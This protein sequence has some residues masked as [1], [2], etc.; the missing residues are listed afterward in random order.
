MFAFAGG[1]GQYAIGLD[2]G[3]VEERLRLPPPDVEA[4]VID[5]LHEDLD[6]DLLEPPAKIAGRGGIGNTLGAED[7]EINLVVAAQLDV[8]QAGSAAKD[9][10]RN[11]EHVVGLVIGQ[12]DLEQT[13]VAVDRLDEAGAPGKQ[14]HGPDPALGQTASP[15]G[16]LVVDVAGGEHRGGLIAPFP[17]AKP[18]FNS[19]LASGKLLTCNGVHSKCLLAYKC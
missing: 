17:R 8:L 9:V 2:D 16:Q 12:V 1:R 5:D 4:H 15:I 18:V 19:A 6:V 13:Q 11:V 10:V 7:V 3:F 14:V